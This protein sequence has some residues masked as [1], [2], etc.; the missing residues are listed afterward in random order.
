MIDLLTSV[1]KRGVTMREIRKTGGTGGAIWLMA[2]QEAV[3]VIIKLYRNVH[4]GG[5]VA[6][7][8][9]QGA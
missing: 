5:V 6:G 9:K 1:M 8:G 2:C 7:G 3:T 4:V